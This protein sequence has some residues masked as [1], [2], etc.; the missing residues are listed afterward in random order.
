LGARVNPGAQASPGQWTDDPARLA[1]WT[2]FHAQVRALPD[3]GYEGM[4]AREARIAV[5]DRPRLR[6]AAERVVHLYEGRGRTEKA[7]AWMARLGMPDLPADVFA[8]P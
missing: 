3:N 5:P 8:P 1:A 4:K 2:K 6:E 7:D